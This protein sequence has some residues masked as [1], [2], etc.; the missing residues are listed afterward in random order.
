Y[1]LTATFSHDSA[2]VALRFPAKEPTVSV[3]DVKTGKEEANFRLPKND[4]HGQ[5]FFTADGQTLYHRQADRRVRPPRRDRAIRVDRRSPA[6]EGPRH[7][8]RPR[9]RGRTTG[10]SV[11]RRLSGRRAGRVRPERRLRSQRQDQGPARRV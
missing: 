3:R 11:S 1:G 6:D 10:V 7:D 2:K 9:R 4:W 5:L 8:C